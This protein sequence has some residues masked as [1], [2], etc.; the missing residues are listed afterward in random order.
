VTY[1]DR[2]DWPNLAVDLVSALYENPDGLDRDELA[3]ELGLSVPQF[4]ELVR[5]ARHYLGDSDTV[6]IICEALAGPRWVY[7][8]VGNTAEAEE[9]RIGR[10]GDARTRLV[11]MAA[12]WASL[13]RG[14]DGRSAEGRVAKATSLALKHLIENIDNELAA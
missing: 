12:V 6:N 3:D 8:L 5:K 1:Y 13:A 7:R 4:Y 2:L 9:W 14:L 10:L 11:T